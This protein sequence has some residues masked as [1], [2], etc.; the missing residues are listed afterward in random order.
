MS[1]STEVQMFRSACGFA[2]AGALLFHHSNTIKDF[3][4]VDAMFANASFAAELGLKCLLRIHGVPAPQVHELKKL[5]ALLPDSERTLLVDRFQK[6]IKQSEFYESLKAI[7]HTFPDDL[8]SA[9]TL[10]NN[11]FV[12]FRYA[13]ELGRP[14]T[15]GLS[16]FVN[17]VLARILD[18][19]VNWTHIWQKQAVLR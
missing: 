5:F 4:S 12:R 9:L 6:A 7:G 14:N 19:R 17:M 16:L 10:W 11:A 1:D 2:T 13:H 3:S 15:A 8:E 18:H